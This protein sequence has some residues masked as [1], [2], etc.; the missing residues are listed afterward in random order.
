MIAALT[1]SV[2]RASAPWNIHVR[3]SAIATRGCQRRKSWR[4][5][6][7][8]PCSGTSTDPCHRCS[9]L[10][11]LRSRRPQPRRLGL[12][13]LCGYYVTLNARESGGNLLTVGAGRFVTG[14]GMP[15]LNGSVSKKDLGVSGKVGRS[16]G[17]TSSATYRSIGKGLARLS[18]HRLEP[19]P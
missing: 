9:P 10:C 7:S 13:S 8:R 18:A 16:N 4:D 3:L 5:H 14:R 11:V 17:H 1:T 2:M 12:F 19:R 6:T 15:G